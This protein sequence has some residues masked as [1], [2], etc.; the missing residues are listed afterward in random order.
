M[1]F[2]EALPIIKNWGVKAVDLRG[3]INGKPIE[4]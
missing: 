4:R 2:Y 1:D 3:R